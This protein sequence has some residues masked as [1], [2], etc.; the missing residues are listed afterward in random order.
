M[1][2]RIAMLLAVVGIPLSLIPQGSTPDESELI[3][4]HSE[5]IRAH[6]EGRVD[7]WMSL[8]S[9][10]FVSVNGGRVTFPDASERREGR[11]AYL[12]TTKFETYRDIRAPIA[13]MSDDG[14]L[15]WLIAE[16]EIEGTTGSSRTPFRDIWAWIEL[17]EKVDDGWRLV[18]NASNR[19]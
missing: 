13:R 11:A 16:V 15:G 6:V 17:Y 12:E 1:S 10:P 19:R 14:T 4:L 8:E 7:V 5:L 3:R 2:M 9:D 18:G